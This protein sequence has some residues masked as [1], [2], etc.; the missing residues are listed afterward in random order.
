MV[1]IDNSLSSIGGVSTK[2]GILPP[3]KNKVEIPLKKAFKTNN[4]G[5]LKATD[6]GS[7]WITVYADK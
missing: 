1:N 6:Y 4:L 7:V 2:C 5:D 3:S